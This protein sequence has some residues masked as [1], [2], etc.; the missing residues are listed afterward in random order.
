M[1]LYRISQ[2]SL[3]PDADEGE[4]RKRVTAVRLI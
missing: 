2:I 3:S 4:L 1:S